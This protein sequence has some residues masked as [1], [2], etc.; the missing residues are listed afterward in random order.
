M[1]KPYQDELKNKNPK[2]YIRY[3]RDTKKYSFQ[4]IGNE[5]FPDLKTAS[6]KRGKAYKWYATKAESKDAVTFASEKT[7]E[8]ARET[9]EDKDIYKKNIARRVWYSRQSLG[10]RRKGKTPKADLVCYFDA[11]RDLSEVMAIID[12]FDTNTAQIN[13]NLELREVKGDYKEGVS[14]IQ[15]DRAKVTHHNKYMGGKWT[16]GTQMTLPDLVGGLKNT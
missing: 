12:R 13:H 11:E 5:L 16:K 10:S 4:E 1:T 6:G 15:L 2:E 7:K 8:R 14:I 9:L 3:L